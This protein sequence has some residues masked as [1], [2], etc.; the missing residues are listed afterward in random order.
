VTAVALGSWATVWFTSTVA[1]AASVVGEAVGHA[2][3]PGDTIVSA[4][5]AADVVRGSGLRSPYPY[6]WSLPAHTLDP[7]L[8]GL[9]ALLE[10]PH[11]PTWIVVNGHGAEAFLR[12]TTGHD[13]SRLYDDTGVLCGRHVFLREGVA[14]PAPRV[15]G[16]CR[17]PV[18]GPLEARLRS[19][20]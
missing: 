3:R 14:R 6:L 7:H 4:L 5:G 9:R 8:E 16:S 2:A 1:G 20:G 10:G 17:G 13:V 11:A 18:T 15:T 19:L 12:A